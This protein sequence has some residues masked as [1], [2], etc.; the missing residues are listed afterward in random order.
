MSLVGNA[1][2]GDLACRGNDPGVTDFGR[3]TR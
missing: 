2:G 1:I 3:R